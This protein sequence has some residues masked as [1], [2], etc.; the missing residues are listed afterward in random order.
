MPNAFEITT[1][2]QQR[3][4]FHPLRLRILN[5]LVRERLTVS[6]VAA[7]LRVHPANI[8]H[9]FRILRRASLIRLV[10]QR[11]IGRVVEKYYAAV[12]EV[13]D[14]RPQAG[15]VRHVG[16]EVLALLRNDL[17]GNLERL[18]A[19]DSDALVGLL[20]SARIDGKRYADF[21]RRL[22][23]LA[24]EFD[25]LNDGEGP[26]YALNLG[27][28]PQRLDYGPIGHYELNRASK[29]APKR[30]QRTR[31]SRKSFTGR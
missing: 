8:T 21:A 15:S 24:K 10:E 12:A 18:K 1:P 4:Y 9:H 3:A 19:D 13:F 23:A 16:R 2:A 6:Q 11:D 29:G 22:G 7:R 27:L 20:V 5:F 31:T 30:A 25:A 17:A 14:V 26:A 28:Y